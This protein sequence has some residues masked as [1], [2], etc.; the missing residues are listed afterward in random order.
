MQ[1]RIE[2]NSR[3]SLL[4]ERLVW[5][6]AATAVLAV[7]ILVLLGTLRW[8][9]QVSPPSGA[10]G[11]RPPVSAGLDESVATDDRKVEAAD[12]NRPSG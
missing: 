5:N 11:A 3:G 12:F 7:M 9:D 1:R 2:S 10:A 6:A 8:L 4:I